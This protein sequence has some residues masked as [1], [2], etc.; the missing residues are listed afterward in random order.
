[1]DCGSIISWAIFGLIVGALA[2]LLWPGRGPAGC[3]STIVLGVAGSVVGGAVT[4]LIMG[5]A[6]SPIE[7]AGLIMSVVGAIVVLW[8]ASAL[9][10][11]GPYE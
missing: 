11:R 6:D 9:T 10:S 2:R 1:M 4:R 3:L 7:P 5:P 8:I